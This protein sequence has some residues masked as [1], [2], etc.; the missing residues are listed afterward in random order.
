MVKQMIRL[1]E[2]MKKYVNKED[3]QTSLWNDMNDK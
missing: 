3:I 1:G 2:D